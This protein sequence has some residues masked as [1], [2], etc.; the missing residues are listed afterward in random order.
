MDEDEEIFDGLAV[1]ME[2]IVGVVGSYIHLISL[3]WELVLLFFFFFSSRR[4]HTRFDCDWSSDVCSSDLGGYQLV[5]TVLAEVNGTPVFADKVLATVDKELAAQARRLDERQF[6]AA[7]AETIQ[8][9]VRVYVYT[10][11]EFAMAQRQLEAKDAQLAKLATIRW[12]D[13]QVTKAGGSLELA[14]QRAAAAGYD[15][16]ELAEEQERLFMR[17]LYFER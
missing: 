15:F 16:D 4:R 17:R 13:E 9:Q 10:E 7:A 12:R 8:R 3:R 11:L 5:G 6:R 14:R 2:E 1:L